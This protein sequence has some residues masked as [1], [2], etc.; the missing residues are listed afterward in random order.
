MALAALTAFSNICNSDVNQTHAG[1]IKNLVEVAVRICEHSKEMFLITEAANFLLSCVW[2]CTINKARYVLYCM[3]VCTALYALYVC[4]TSLIKQLHTASYCRIASK[5][6]CAVLVKQIIG[7]APRIKTADD[8]Y[9]RTTEKLCLALSSIL[10]YPNSH[11]RMV[12]IGT[13]QY[14]TYIHTYIVV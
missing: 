3:Y 4:I 2:N 12:V 8:E 7:H 6:A 13:L 11:E 5:N 9:M 10:I 14:I 1:S